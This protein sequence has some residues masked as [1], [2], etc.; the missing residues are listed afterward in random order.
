MA[1]TP[2]GPDGVLSM[3]RLTRRS[4]QNRAGPGSS[5]SV[6]QSTDPVSAIRCRG[7][8]TSR[9]LSRPTRAASPW[10]PR[11]PCKGD[12][13]DL[14]K[15]AARRPQTLSMSRRG[16]ALASRRHPASTSIE[17]GRGGATAMRAGG[18]RGENWR[19]P[20]AHDSLMHASVQKYPSQKFWEPRNFLDRNGSWRQ[21]Q[22]RSR[23]PFF[24]RKRQGIS[25]WNWTHGATISEFNALRFGCDSYPELALHR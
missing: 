24:E 13:P 12:P 9:A 7:R 18:G 6:G 23:N 2:T 14:A 19:R 22:P 15:F 25:Q 17:G 10:P 3:E 1:H 21:S 8:G 4:C 5:P 11:G 16:T 20:Q